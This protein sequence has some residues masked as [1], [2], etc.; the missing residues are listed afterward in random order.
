MDDENEEE[1]MMKLQAKEHMRET[2]DKIGK[3]KDRILECNSFDEL[4]SYLSSIVKPFQNNG[5]HGIDLGEEMNFASFTIENDVLR[6]L[7]MI[8]KTYENIY[9][10][11]KKVGLDS[12]IRTVDPEDLEYLFGQLIKEAGIPVKK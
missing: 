7:S 6:E 12:N 3:I 9:E 8:K 10:M 4:N 1:A 11:L 2:L 5:V